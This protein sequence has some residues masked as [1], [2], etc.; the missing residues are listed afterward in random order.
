MWDSINSFQCNTYAD[1]HHP[2]ISTCFLA[3]MMDGTWEAEWRLCLLKTLI[4]EE[5][6]LRA[7]LISFIPIEKNGWSSKCRSIKARRYLCGAHLSNCPDHKKWP[8]LLK[9]EES[10][11]LMTKERNVVGERRSGF[12]SHPS[13]NK[14]WLREDHEFASPRKTTSMPLLH[15][16][17]V[18]EMEVMG[19]TNFISMAYE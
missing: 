16:L 7:L 14:Q 6:F 4:E 1:L 8:L 10:E 3:S 13:Q 18:L 12:C 15:G 17:V 11:S 19:P 2:G 5:T 9:R